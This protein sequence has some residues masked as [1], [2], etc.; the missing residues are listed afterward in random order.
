MTNKE[1]ETWNKMVWQIAKL[2]YVDDNPAQ[3]K[4]VEDTIAP[5]LFGLA[6][7]IIKEH[8]LSNI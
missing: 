7:E 2:G 8:L 6:K 1:K 5:K 4:L 3:K